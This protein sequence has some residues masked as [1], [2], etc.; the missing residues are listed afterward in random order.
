MFEKDFYDRFLRTLA[1]HEAIELR[2]R[3]LDVDATTNAFGFK[4][5]PSLGAKYLRWVHGEKHQYPTNVILAQVGDFYCLYGIDAILGIEFA[6]LRANG[7]KTKKMKCGV[8]LSGVQPLLNQFTKRGFTVRI[9]EETNQRKYE[10][11][12]GGGI[13]H[14]GLSQVISA[15]N[16]VFSKSIDLETSETMGAEPIVFLLRDEV[17]VVDVP[18]RTYTFSL[19][20]TFQSA[21]DHSVFLVGTGKASIQTAVRTV[22][23]RATEIK[24]CK[25]MTIPADFTRAQ[26]LHSVKE[27]YALGNDSSFTLIF[28]ESSRV[29][30]LRATADQLGLVS[31]YREYIPSLVDST[32]GRGSHAPEKE[33]MTKWLVAVPSDVGRRAMQECVQNVLSGRTTVSTKRSMGTSRVFGLLYAAKS[34]IGETHRVL[35]RLSNLLK[36]NRSAFLNADVFNVAL[37]SIGYNPSS[38]TYATYTKQVQR[39]HSLLGFKLLPS[40]GGLI[41][42][43]WVTEA[44]PEFPTSFVKRNSPTMTHVPSGIIQQLKTAYTKLY[45]TT[46]Q[47]TSKHR[48]WRC[49]FYE[50]ENDVALVSSAKKT[51]SQPVGFERVLSRSPNRKRSAFTTPELVES[52]DEFLRACQTS[53]AWQTEEIQSVCTRL[54]SEFKTCVSLILQSEVVLKAVHNHLTQT[55]PAGW[56][57][58]SVVEESGG[59]RSPVPIRIRGLFPYWMESTEGKVVANNVTLESGS[60]TFVTSPNAGGKTTLIRSLVSA[61]LL[62]S[63]GL[64]IPARQC[65]IPKLRTVCMRLPA[66]DRPVAGLSNFEA[67]MADIRAILASADDHSVVCLDELC[68][69]TSSL[70]ST[71]CCQAIIESLQAKGC[72]TLVSTH[73]FNLVHKMNGRKL[74]LDSNHSL[75]AGYVTTSDAVRVCAAMGVPRECVDRIS[76]LISED[77]KRPPPTPPLASMSSQRR[78]RQKVTTTTDQMRTICLE[79]TG[80]EAPPHVVG[81]GDEIPPMLLQTSCV[82][83]IEESDDVF[84]VGETEHV[85]NRSSQHKKTKKRKK[86]DSWKISIYPVAN[87]S[88]ARACEKKIIQKAIES[89]ILLMSYHDAGFMV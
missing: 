73:D 64:F 83:L 43:S 61:L 11:E 34:N 4:E 77:N 7:K 62:A 71:A 81:P 82:Y 33:F 38:Y 16:P 35:A 17:L 84:Y 24:N 47:L 49:E 12:A 75:K 60:T 67:E 14:R 36:K 45:K 31:G 44:P 48:G 29:G 56:S 88:R 5:E 40:S 2:D 27:K 18:T 74:K 41:P 57:M 15:A 13:K 79:Q 42:D 21:V 70:E 1:S 78:K 26:A 89:G 86:K 65:K 9:Y 66:T 53:L 58:A 10:P 37:E 59:E 51:K 87:K 46:D 22:P 6:N 55:I 69:S 32:V 63:A 50:R 52:V 85:I 28:W 80:N 30:V 39:V 54:T 68:R 76:Q 3:C 8:I 25:K 20:A 72:T 19:G 23:S